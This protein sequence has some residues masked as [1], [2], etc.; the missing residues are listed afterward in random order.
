MGEV[1]IQSCG[2]F[3]DSVP[4][5]RH[6][7][8]QGELLTIHR[9]DCCNSKC[10]SC[11]VDKRLALD[12]PMEQSDTKTVSWRKYV[13]A[14]VIGKDGLAKQTTSSAAVTAAE[15]TRSGS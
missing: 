5:H 1:D 8:V 7:H 4:V 10:D 3:T 11:G 9:R 13:K 12:C 6:R 2:E 15:T 14:T